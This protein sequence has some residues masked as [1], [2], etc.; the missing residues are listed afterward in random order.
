MEQLNQTWQPKRQRSN[1]RNRDETIL[2]GAN[3]QGTS[4]KIVVN[5]RC[6]AETSVQK[7]ACEK[8]NRRQACSR[9]NVV[10]Q[11]RDRELML[12]RTKQHTN[13]TS[14]KC[15][16]GKNVETGRRNVEGRKTSEEQNVE[17]EATSVRNMRVGRA[18]QRSERRTCE[19][20][21]PGAA[22][23]HNG[24]GTGTEA[25]ND[26]GTGRKRQNTCE[27]RDMRGHEWGP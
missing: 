25:T 23:M 24:R 26:R 16:N 6:R 14:N 10:Q 21:Q 13:A 4:D 12:E 20:N 7:Q 1:E 9:M 18:V 27:R 17:A 11:M 3:G 2:R 8:S 19:G 15:R 5:D 22:E